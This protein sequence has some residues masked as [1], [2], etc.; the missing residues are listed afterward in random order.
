MGEMSDPTRQPV[1]LVADGD[2]AFRGAARKCLEA[3]GARV[4]EAPGGEAALDA[5]AIEQ[6]DLVWVEADLPDLDGATVCSEIRSADPDGGAVIVILT[7]P[8]DVQGIEDAYHAGASDCLEKPLDPRRLADRA[9]FLIGGRLDPALSRARKTTNLESAREREL[10]LGLAGALAHGELAIHYQPIVNLRSTRVVGF[11]ALLRWNHPEL[12]SISPGEFIPVAERTG[13]IRSIGEW[14]LVQACAQNRAWQEAGFEKLRMSVNVSTHQIRNQ[15]LAAIVRRALVA[16]RLEPQF[17]ELEITESATLGNSDRCASMLRAVK[18]IGVRVAL[19]DFGTGY[20]SLSYLKRFPV[21]T[22]KIDRAFVQ[23]LPGDRDVSGIASAILALAQV[24]E[25]RV[26]AE[27][28]ET[29][30]QAVFLRQRGCDAIQG[31]LV[32]PAVDAEHAE[33]FLIRGPEALEAAA[34][35]PDP[36]AESGAD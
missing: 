6:P 2:S 27:G 23:D 20:S 15:D 14:V 10:E 21:N 8:E 34:L 19:D 33:R 31:F 12:G 16:S 29:E 24:L 11:E 3:I 5:F 13:L 9:R 25:L 32:S 36:R 17:L 4:V 28:V 7:S 18:S 1:V 30:E 35:A 26:V 22:L